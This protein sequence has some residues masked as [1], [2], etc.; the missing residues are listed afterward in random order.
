VISRVLFPAALISFTL[1]LYGFLQRRVEEWDKAP[2]TGVI[3]ANFWEFWRT[4]ADGFL[5]SPTAL[6]P[7]GPAEFLGPLD[8]GFSLRHVLSFFFL[9][10]AQLG[11]F[12]QRKP[13]RLMMDGEIRGF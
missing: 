1:L 3:L 12:H 10:S 9:R 11:M 2:R 8:V 6:V 5:V 13:A 7:C 4:K